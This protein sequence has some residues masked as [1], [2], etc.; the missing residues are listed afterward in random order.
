MAGQNYGKDI[1]FHFLQE[2]W[3]YINRIHGQGKVF[4]RMINEFD[5]MNSKFELAQMKEFYRIIGKR[6]G[7][8][9]SYFLQ[10]IDQIEANIVWVA[11]YQPEIAKFLRARQSS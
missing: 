5:S 1:A 9:K 8:G 4:G 2:N 10:T 6:I 3:Q 11:K 7:I